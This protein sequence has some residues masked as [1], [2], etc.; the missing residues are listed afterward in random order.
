MRRHV[1][2]GAA[3]VWPHSE[4]RKYVKVTYV[5]AHV[6]LDVDVFSKPL[7]TQIYTSS[8]HVNMCVPV[9]LEM[10]LFLRAMISL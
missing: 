7:V 1:D 6:I 8:V 3:V 4:P 10:R 5:L 2:S 9:L